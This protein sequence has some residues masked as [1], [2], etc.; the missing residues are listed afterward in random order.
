MS[1]RKSRDSLVCETRGRRRSRLFEEFDGSE[2][3]LF[4]DEPQG[5]IDDL[6]KVMMRFYRMKECLDFEEE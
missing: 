1:L 2:Y 6:D 5:E 4:P 3:E